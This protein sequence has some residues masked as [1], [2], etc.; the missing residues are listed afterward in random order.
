MC[1]LRLSVHTAM[2]QGRHGA[3]PV[4]C[5]WPLPQDEWHQQTAHQTTETAGKTHKLCSVG[6][7]GVLY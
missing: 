1:Q 5:L 4:Q 3:L 7:M 6:W 2:A